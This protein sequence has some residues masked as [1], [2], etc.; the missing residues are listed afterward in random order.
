LDAD[1][2]AEPNEWGTDDPNAGQNQ[3]GT[4]D[5]N[6]EQNQWGTDDPNADQNQWGT[7]DPNAEQNQWDADQNV[8]EADP[9]ADQNVLE[10]DPNAEP[11]DYQDNQDEEIEA[12]DAAYRT[13]ESGDHGNGQPIQLPNENWITANPDWNDNQVR[14]RECPFIDFFFSKKFNKI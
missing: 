11:N 1:P 4:D 13:V 12:T 10:A 9:N 3:W 8:L 7:D 6:A 2:N 5:P 14:I